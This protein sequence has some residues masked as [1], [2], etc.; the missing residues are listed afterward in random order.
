MGKVFS[1]PQSDE[2]NESNKPIKLVKFKYSVPEIKKLR[3][4]PLRLSLEVS[5]PESGQSTKCENPI[6][7]DMS[8]LENYLSRIKEETEAI[9][10]TKLQLGPIKVEKVDVAQPF[11]FTGGATI[12]IIPTYPSALRFFDPSKEKII[13][14]V[15]EEKKQATLLLTDKPSSPK[16][17]M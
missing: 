16:S 13:S 3:I 17:G 10:I 2:L 11:K 1:K 9:K 6:E 15:K 5:D 8:A 4:D 14:G 12:Q 7:I